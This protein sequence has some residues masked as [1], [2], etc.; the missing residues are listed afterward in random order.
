MVSVLAVR[1]A[2]WGQFGLLSRPYHHPLSTAYSG[3][4]YHGETDLLSFYCPRA[5]LSLSLSGQSS[6]S[7]QCDP[8]GHGASAAV[9]K[10]YTAA[11]RSQPVLEPHPDFLDEKQAA[12]MNK[13]AHAVLVFSEGFPAGT[14]TLFRYNP[15]FWNMIKFTGLKR[16]CEAIRTSNGQGGDFGIVLIPEARQAHLKKSSCHLQAALP[17]CSWLLL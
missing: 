2:T 4:P 1:A 17:C 15:V 13:K 14:E 7:V 6:A 12:S 16:N 11:A 9:P 5:W 8:A 10:L 3:F